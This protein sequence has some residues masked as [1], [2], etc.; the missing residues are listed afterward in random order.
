MDTVLSAVVCDLVSRCISFII[1]K[2]QAQVSIN[3]DKISRLQRLLLRAGTVVEEAERRQITNHGM[4]LQLKQLREAMYRGCYMLDT[5][6]MQD[7]RPKRWAVVSQC[8]LQSATDNLEATLDGMKEF[9]LILMHC[10]PIFR[11]PYSAYMFMERCM[12]GRHAEKE[13]IISF[14]LHPCSSLDVLPVIGPCYVGKRT[15]V[16]HA[17]REE[18][19]QRNFSHIL[20]FSRDLNNLGATGAMDNCRKLAS[21]G[22]RLLIVVELIHEIDELVWE[23][24]YDSLSHVAGGSKAILISRME[25]VSNLGTVQPLKLKRLPEE[26]YWYFFRVLAFGSANPYDHNPELTS[27]A[28]EMA[29][30][31]DGSFMIPSTITR[32][33]RANLNVQYWRRTLEY[34]RKSIQMTK[35]VFGEYPTDTQSSRRYLSYFHCFRHD[36]ATIFCYNRY[37]ARSLLQRDI[38]NM[39][40]TEYLLSAGDLEYGEK[41]DI[42]I[43]SHI[44]PYHNYVLNCVVEKS[45]R[46]HLGNKCH[47]RKRIC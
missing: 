26:E 4:L 46:V 33:L 24:L 27:I 38:E 6:G 28:K 20:C 45:K 39:R 15:L 29:T 35:S 14:L 41:F 42:I 8:K 19:V 17:C 40:M 16:E 21:S 36:G 11:Q 13:H 44:P 34:I 22:G 7:S 47:K 5:A 23:K 18:I 31:I 32:L 37:R 25:K 43:Q 1:S 2:S 12:F 9:L 10:P 30:E 3:E